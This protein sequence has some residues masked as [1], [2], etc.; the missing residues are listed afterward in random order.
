MIRRGDLNHR[1]CVANDDYG[2]RGNPGSFKGPLH[3]ILVNGDDFKQAVL[4]E[5]AVVVIIVRD[6]R[7][8]PRLL[9]P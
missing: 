7:F 5:I 2:S 1:E 3:N 8:L 9:V 6:Y 4:D